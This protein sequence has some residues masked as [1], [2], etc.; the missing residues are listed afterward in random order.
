MVV[1]FD[2]DMHATTHCVRASLWVRAKK[3]SHGRTVL[4]ECYLRT[5]RIHPE[6][7]ARQRAKCV[8]L[9][10]LVF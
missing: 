5:S 7:V 4:V 3:K 9:R 2:H 10:L 1:F 8:F 6:A